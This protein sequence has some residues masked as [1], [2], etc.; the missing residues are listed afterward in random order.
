MKTN[1]ITT[2]QV[3]EWLGPDVTKDDLIEIITDIANFN[4]REIDTLREDI[5]HGVQTQDI[6]FKFLNCL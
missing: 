3:S 6:P 5:V 2:Y 1:A 4:Y